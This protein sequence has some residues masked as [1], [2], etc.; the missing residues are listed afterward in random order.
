[1]DTPVFR[2]RAEAGRRIA[3]ALLRHRDG[4]PVVMGVPRGGIIIASEI[5]PAVQ[6]RL[7]L[8]IVRRISPPGRPDATVGAI[9]DG[10]D[11]EIFCDEALLGEHGMSQ[12]AFSAQVA[13]L[14]YA[15]ALQ[16]N[17]YGAGRPRASVQNRMV[18][19]ADDAIVTGRDGA[20]GLARAVQGARPLCRRRGARGRCRVSP[21]A[22]RRLRRGGR[23]RRGARCRVGP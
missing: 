21:G 18:I 6:G 22:A 23:P 13:R 17:R 2:D 15:I 3:Q 14:R 10:V 11:I 8:M 12:A 20:R 16:Q 1:M 7:D 4:D 9:A 5:A 19:L